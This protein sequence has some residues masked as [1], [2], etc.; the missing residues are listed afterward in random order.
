LQFNLHGSEPETVKVALQE[1]MAAS[2]HSRNPEQVATPGS[3][4]AQESHPTHDA[5]LREACISVRLWNSASGVSGSAPSLWESEN[6]DGGL[7]LDLIAASEGV[8]VAREGEVLVAGFSSFYLAILAA[9]RLQWA[10]QGFSEVG[11]PQAPCLAVLVHAPEDAPGQTA[12]GN[13][14]RSLK[15]ATPG[16]I[17]L[18][19]E[20]SRSFENLPGFPMKAASGK[21]LRELLWHVPEDQSTRNSDEQILSQLVEQQAAQAAQ[22]ARNQPQVQP[23]Q[24]DTV[25]TEAVVTG[26]LE[27]PRFEFSREKSRWV[28]GGVALAV[29][30]LAVVAILIFHGKP[31]PASEQAQAAP[32]PA[33]ASGAPVAQPSSAGPANPVGRAETQTQTRAGKNG[34]KGAEKSLEA[35]A[36]AIAP[37]PAAKPAEPPP[38]PRG[39]CDLEPSQYSGQIDLAWKNLGRGKYADAQR[40][41]GAVLTCDPGNGRAREG[42]E[43]ARMAAREADGQS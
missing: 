15:H 29:V 41:F 18:T 6:P 28:I 27:P 35:T 16:Q 42:L 30:V 33:A 43:R 4:R 37:Q 2:T 20:A 21:G 5:G 22:D 38:A 1:N 31:N 32:L 34:A 3:S 12:G 39:R 9:R 7:V 8:P 10:V 24:P 23:A 14:P 13:F 17:L 26:E 40:E 19:A 36:P 25:L 11:N